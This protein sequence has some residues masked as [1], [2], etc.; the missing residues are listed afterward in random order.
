MDTPCFDADGTLKLL[1]L[2]VNPYSD[3]LKEPESRCL[4]DK[5]VEDLGSSRHNLW[6]NYTVVTTTSSGNSRGMVEG[7]QEEFR[8][9]AT[10]FF[11]PLTPRG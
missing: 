7:S 4:G 2:L 5:A 6:N 1:D 10:F 9:V 3:V 11:D 8:C